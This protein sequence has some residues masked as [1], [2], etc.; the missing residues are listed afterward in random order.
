MKRS[1]ALLCVMAALLALPLGA[2]V[3][4]Y[5]DGTPGV[6]GFRSEVLAEVMIQE[7]KFVRL[8]KAVPADKYTWRPV[9][10]VRSIAEVF[11]HVA[12]ANYN[13][14]QIIGAAPP[15][16]F[17]GKTF[18]KSTTDK[19]KIVAALRDSFAHARKAISAMPDTDLEKRMDWFGGKNTERGVL[20]FAVRHGAEHLGQAIADARVNGV[21]PPWT[22]DALK[23]KKADAK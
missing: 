17:D 15:A 3:N 14:Y 11:L 12:T 13:I 20:L 6:T 18:E 7:D 5:K 21:V 10:E 22:E 2:Q 16:G 23:A 19:T 1:L 8:A 9:P 4:P